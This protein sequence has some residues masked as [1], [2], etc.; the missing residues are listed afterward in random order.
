MLEIDCPICFKLCTSIRSI[1]AHIRMTHKENAKDVLFEKIPKL[2]RKCLNCKKRI[3]HF[4]TDSQSR[5]CCNKECD[6]L[7]R[8]GKK[9]DKETI[10]KRIENTNQIEREKKRQKTFIE[11]YNSM[12]APKNEKSRNNKISESLKGK[13]HTEEHHLK[14]IESKRKMEHLIIV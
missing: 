6:R 5:K 11:K 1:S 10:R 8:V 14:V 12:Y 2:F 3:K 4:K 7:S 13:I 9:Q